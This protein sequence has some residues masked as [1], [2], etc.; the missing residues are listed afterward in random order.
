[1]VLV[2]VLCCPISAVMYVLEAFMRLLVPI[3]GPRYTNS[4]SALRDLCAQNLPFFHL[5]LRRTE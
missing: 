1:M 2:M 4:L 5:L 3:F